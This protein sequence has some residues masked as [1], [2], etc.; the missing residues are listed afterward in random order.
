VCVSFVYSTS[1]ILLQLVTEFGD[2]SV[3][4]LNIFT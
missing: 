4:K 2:S 1:V 3:R